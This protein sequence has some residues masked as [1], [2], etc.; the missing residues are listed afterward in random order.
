[1]DQTSITLTALTGT[2]LLLAAA[3]LLPQRNP[4]LRP[5]PAMADLRAGWYAS[6][7]AP[8][9][10]GGSPAPAAAPAPAATT[11]IDTVARRKLLR[12]FGWAT[13]LAILGELAAGFLPFFWPRR[14]GAFGGTVPAGNVSD[15]QVGDVKKIVEGKFFITRVPE[16]FLALWQKCPHLG[17]SVPWI[18]NGPSLDEI[19]PLGR[20]NCPCHGSLYDRYG[21]I[22]GGPAPR[23]MDMFPLTITGGRISVVTT[24]SGVKQRSVAEGSDHNFGP[25]PA[26]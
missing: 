2:A 18:D 3:R 12:W 24:P 9:A 22:K 21:Q 6:S 8:A 15:Y 19:K 20:F 4:A 16:G 13:L 23:P 17:C 5:A 11:P 25:V 7:T 1:M 26:A 10:G 14:T